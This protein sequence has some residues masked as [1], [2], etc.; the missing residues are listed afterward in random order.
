MKRVLKYCS[1]LLISYFVYALIASDPY[2]VVENL[3]NGYFLTHTSQEDRAIGKDIKSDSYSYAVYGH[4]VNVIN[5]KRFLSATRVPRDSLEKD[6]S[7]NGLVRMSWKE[8]DSL[9]A[10]SSYKVYYIIDKERKKE[11]GPY[12]FKNYQRK[13]RELMVVSTYK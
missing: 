9:F 5:G 11:Y 3:G 13:Y 2:Y 6:A 10:N 12:S 1:L 7:N 8:K 4:V